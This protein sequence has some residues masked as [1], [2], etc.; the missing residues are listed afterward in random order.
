[1]AGFFKLPHELY[2]VLRHDAN[3]V[4]VYIELASRA[5]WTPGRHLGSHGIVDLGSGQCAF[6]RGELARVLG[7]TEQNVRTSIARLQKLGAV[8][9]D[10]TN[11]GTIATIR[12][13]DAIAAPTPANQPSGNP[14]DNQGQPPAIDQQ[15]T[16]SEEAR[17][18]EDKKVDPVRARA[19][20]RG[21]RFV[22]AEWAPKPEQ[23]LALLS[24][25]QYE[26]ELSKFRDHEF[27][28]PKSDWDRAWSN[29]QRGAS[30]VTRAPARSRGTLIGS[31]NPD[32]NHPDEQHARPF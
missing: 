24:S 20:A 3:T 15:V 4:R 27:K 32:A 30:H 16:T 10:S 13:V 12:D 26:L 7:M 17:R 18:T 14:V 29:W 6:G 1:M 31:S 19:R 9:V 8:T 11:L 21:S 23:N 2:R 28:S 5:R 22:P 25:E